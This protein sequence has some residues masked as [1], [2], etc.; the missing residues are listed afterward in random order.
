MEKSAKKIS[1]AAGGTGGHIFP[2]QALSDYLVELGHEVTLIHDKRAE[3]FLQGSFTKIKKHQILSSKTSAIPLSRV[4]SLVYLLISTLSL[5]LS[6]FKNKPDI[7][8][9]FGGYTSFPAMCAAQ[10]LGVP[11]AIHEQNAVIGKVNKLFLP[12]AKVLAISI[13]NTIGIDK[14][15]KAKELFTGNLIRKQINNQ[16]INK[17]HNETFTIV[18]IGGSQGAKIFSD[19]IP[20]AV[21]TLP[22]EVQ[23]KISLF[24][25]ARENTLDI[26]KKAL[27]TFAGKYKVESFFT[28]IESLYQSA[29]IIISRA[30]ASTIAE[31]T[32]FK[33]PSILV[34]LPSSADNHQF[35]NA[36]YLVSYGC[37]LLCEQ[38]NFTA[39]Y[40]ADELNRLIHNPSY[41]E[42]MRSNFAE[43][44]IDNAILNFAERILKTAS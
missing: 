39:N 2:A 18:V 16:T 17:I 26:T 4:I 12:A 42:E 7:V 5:C 31:I 36:L 22:V 11:I 25:Q 9:G 14:K 24:L 32:H 30:G 1:I 13:P 41:L 15:F 23:K 19:I 27:S 10:L 20:L 3:K 44:K 43:I 28:D 6:F 35:Y 8:I 38:N 34:P 40:L 29:D 33:A 37:S 21:N